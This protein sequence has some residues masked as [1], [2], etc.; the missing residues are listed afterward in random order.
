MISHVETRVG[1]QLE[2]YIEIE[3]KFLRDWNDLHNIIES[4]NAIDILPRQTLQQTNIE[5]KSIG[6][7]S[8]ELY[9]LS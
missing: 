5:G 1:N 7:Y 9:R 6:T 4:L 3:S 2:V 8:V